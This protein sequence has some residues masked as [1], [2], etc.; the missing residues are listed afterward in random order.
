MKGI[1]GRG[2]VG[3]GTLI[4]EDFPPF[5]TPYSATTQRVTGS[6]RWLTVELMWVTRFSVWGTRLGAFV[7][8][9]YQ[10]ETLNAFG[11]SQIATNAIACSGSSV[12]STA[13]LAITQDNK[14]QAARIGVEGQ[15]ALSDRLTLSGEAAWL[16][17]VW[18]DGND[19]HWLRIGCRA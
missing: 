12:L 1:F 7:G 10:H 18:L 11:C 8:Y 17:Y 6:A 3:H 9:H 2:A 19:F 5:T 15:I 4:D 13:I 14:W 16:P